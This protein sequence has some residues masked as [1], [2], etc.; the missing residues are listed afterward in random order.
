ME[1]VVSTPCGC[2]HRPPPFAD[3]V[4]V[5]ANGG[6]YDIDPIHQNQCNKRCLIAPSSATEIHSYTVRW[7]M[8]IVSSEATSVKPW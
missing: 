3:N 6:Y 5:F 4:H 1:G 8:M 2:P 7:A